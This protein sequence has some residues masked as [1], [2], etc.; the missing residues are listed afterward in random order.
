MI[1][2]DRETDARI[3]AA[4]RLGRHSGPAGTDVTANDVTANDVTAND[5]TANDVTANDVTVTSG[6]GRR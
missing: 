1:R 6:R 2:N 5:V 3:T 4:A